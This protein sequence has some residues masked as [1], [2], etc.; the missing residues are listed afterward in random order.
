MEKRRVPLDWDG[1][2]QRLVKEYERKEKEEFGLHS[3]NT[4][5][6][7]LEKGKAI[8]IPIPLILGGWVGSTVD[9]KVSRWEDTINWAINNKLKYVVDELTDEDYYYF[10]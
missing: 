5:N 4:S 6:N 1:M 2:F 10:D 8:G 7:Y 3:H 9:E